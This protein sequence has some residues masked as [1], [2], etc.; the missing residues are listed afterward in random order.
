MS[1]KPIFAPAVM[2]TAATIV[3]WHADV[4]NQFCLDHPLYQNCDAATYPVPQTPD[5]RSE[6]PT[7]PLGQLMVNLMPTANS[8]VTFSGSG[9]SGPL[10]T[11]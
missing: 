4:A 3:I 10:K 2:L 7:V 8:T 1:K 11:A 5:E 6:M 9:A